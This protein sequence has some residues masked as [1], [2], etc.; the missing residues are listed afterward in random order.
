MAG[1]KSEKTVLD[2]VV[3]PVSVVVNVCVYIYSFTYFT[4]NMYYIYIHSIYI[5]MYYIYTQYIYI[6]I[7]H[8]SSILE[9]LLKWHFLGN[10]KVM[11]K[12]MV[13]G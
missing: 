12:S 10:G 2:K 13:S 4:I 8:R 5:N 6:C 7:D 1:G 9:T 3:S 11:G